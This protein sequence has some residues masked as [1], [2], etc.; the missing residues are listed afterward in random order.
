M[1]NMPT[2]KDLEKRIKELEALLVESSERFN[3]IY[4][5]L[6]EFIY[7]H[8]LEGNF[9]EINLQFIGQL[10]YSREELIRM[11]VREIMPDRYHKYFNEYLK[12]VTEN[13]KDEGLIQVLA[14]NGDIHIIEYTNMII[15]TPAGTQGVLGIARDVT[16]RLETE[17]ALIESDMRF[18]AILESIEDGY[19]E[20]DL[21]GNLT[22]FNNPISENL[23]YTEDELI[24][25][26]YKDYMDE[27]NARIIFESFHRVFKTGVSAKTIEWELIRK[28]GVKMFVEAS[29][30]LRK[31]RKE[32]PIGFQG[33]I[34]DITDRKRSE[35][36][37]AFL[38][39]HDAL[40]GLYN[41]KAF[42]ER[43]DETLKDAKR[44]ENRKAVLYLDL[45]KFKKVNDLYG[46]E[47]GDRLLVEV[48]SRLRTI[49]RENDYISRLG[50][51]EFTIILSNSQE[52]KPEKVAQRILE[53]LSTPYDLS[54]ITIDFVTP[55]I[56]ISTYPDDGN[57]V[58]T[59]LKH[60]DEAM[61]KAK[62]KG[63]RYVHYSN[64]IYQHALPVAEE[65]Q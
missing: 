59:L 43:F 24:G 44:Y 61:Y 7:E 48:S 23:G 33:I 11:N 9:T 3:E 28:D 12:R 57:D 52:I 39:Y 1:A 29:V 17:Q 4:R 18:R 54:G 42:L 53:K 32:E 56:G 5:N 55:S 49:L 26:N 16:D 36:E 19:Y 31:N 38:A 15:N 27:E 21:E 60:A 45:D 63:N 62:E 8:D 41:R 46:H 50:G 37:L 22:F 35:K 25:K 58:E 47:I 6:S 34:R 20:V 13:G 10:G 40:T 14:K 2:Y 51:D 64:F 30:N 65:S